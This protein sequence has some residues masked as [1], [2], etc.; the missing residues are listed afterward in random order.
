MAANAPFSFSSGSTNGGR[1]M[2]KDKK[3]TGMVRE[4]NDTP[5]VERDIVAGVLTECPLSSFL[6]EFITIQL[7]DID[8]DYF[9]RKFSDEIDFTKV[10]S[11]GPWVVYDRYLIVQPWTPKL[12][13]LKPYPLNVVAW[14][15]LSS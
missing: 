15:R 13:A 4:E 5:L 10:L 12:S 9:L 3:G 14:I 7:M 11:K 6:T 2:K 1:V 8:T